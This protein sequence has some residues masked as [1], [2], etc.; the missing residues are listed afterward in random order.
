MKRRDFLKRGSVAGFGLAGAGIVGGGGLSHLQGAVRE[1]AVPRARRIIFVAYDGFNLEDLAF[2]R[3]YAQHNRD[4][5]LEIERLLAVGSSGSMLTHSLTSVVTDSSAAATAWS[6]GRKIVNQQV[7]VF[8]D[9]TP[10]TSILHLARD[11]G[12]GTGLVT[13][14][15]I[16]HATPAS[17]WA[18]T[19]NR[20]FEEEI[21]IQYLDSGMDVLLGGGEEFFLP[22]VRSDERDMFAEFAGKGYQVLR[23]QEQLL[24]ATGDRLLG[25]FTRG[26]VAYEIDRVHQGVP[27]PS[28]AEMTQKGLEVLD[29]NPEGFVLQVE[30]GRVDH[31]NHDNDPGSVLHEILAGDEA[32]RVVLD[33]ADRTP[34]TLVIVGSDHATSGGV[35]Y[36]RGTSYRLSTE[37]LQ[38]VVRQKSSY[39]YFRSSLGVGPAA[40]SVAMASAELLGIR[41]NE[42]DLERV[43]AI[44]NGDGR[45][46]HRWAHSS[47]PLNSLH[48]ALS[49][50]TV[51]GPNDPATTRQGWTPLPGAG[52]RL[53]VNYASGTHTAGLVPVA[54]YGAGVPTT[55]L[56]IVDN[57]ELYDLMCAALGI[58]FQNP[59]MSEAEG[60]EAFRV[61]SV[62]M[63]ESDRPHWV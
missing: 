53:N 13:T 52:L 31:A 1:G 39:A 33:Y 28:L 37:A 22:E 20:D 25:V 51:I 45:L 54:I 63:A 32:L 26:H 48:Q 56:G 6:T 30:V 2:A 58:S 34:G 44:L 55:G 41:L 57:T 40:E 15:R 43:T 47:Q 7:C 60:L 50:A 8:P 23:T 38:E 17:W 27:S 46:G 61:A 3:Y 35:V 4:R 12:M 14:A 42:A 19:L 5:V 9:G 16:T 10:L 36:G 11:R 18:Q 62:A 24:N 59:I 21:A 29:G 49:Q